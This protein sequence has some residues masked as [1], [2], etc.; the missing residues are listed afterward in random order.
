MI[1]IFQLIIILLLKQFNNYNMKIKNN[2]IKNI[3]NKSNNN[4][5]SIKENIEYLKHSDN[6]NLD[7]YD[8]NNYNN[9]IINTTEDLLY[10]DINK[11]ITDITS[12][13][14]FD[15]NI[16]YIILIIYII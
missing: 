11:N 16:I 14:S 9:T 6:Y 13:Y 5:N 7:S 1:L 15:N 10:K 3:I 12:N 8:N 2:D 4:L